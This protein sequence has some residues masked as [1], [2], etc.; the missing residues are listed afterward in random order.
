MTGTHASFN[1]VTP[2]THFLDSLPFDWSDPGARE[3][4]GLLASFYDEPAAVK[5]MAR[6]AGIATQYVPWQQPVYGV[7]FDLITVARNQGM[8]RALLAQI[9]A[10]PDRAVAERLKE[11]IGDRPV[12][13]V[14]EP[15]PPPGAWKHFTDPDSLERQIFPDSTFQDVAFLRRGTE[16][17]T[18]V[19]RLRV[20]DSQGRRYH[21]TA[22]RVGTD[23]LMTS[24][25][26]LHGSDGDR[27]AQV[28]A[29]FGYEQDIDGRDLEHVTVVCDPASV[30]G[31]AE[32][33]W[34]VI[35][36]AEPM[37]EDAVV[38]PL[39]ERVT[40]EAGDRVCIIQHPH[41]GVK[42][43]AA[44]HNVVRYADD[45]VVQYWTDTDRGSSGAPVFDE[46]W[47][48][49]AL[50]RCHTRAGKLSEQ[51]EYRNEGVRIERVVAGMANAGL[52]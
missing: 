51:R 18:A 36:V 21:G 40:V 46:R 35:R 4:Q 2:M 19:C 27:M 20:T 52:R 1:K 31:D 29:W 16:Q 3:L 6:Q 10:G 17:A 44:R 13:E 32:D 25:H 8:L 7:W 47:R 41:G 49:V 14:P 38:V 9:L 33:D 48:L 50:H 37:P 5:A 28:E 30:T 34:A 24:H 15:E 43:L 12:L 11:L 22:F 39:P 45:Q 23:L 26:V 42:K